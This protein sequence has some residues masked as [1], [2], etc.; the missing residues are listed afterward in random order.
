M[1]SIHD[2]DENVNTYETYIMNLTKETK[3]AIMRGD[4]ETK[5]AMRWKNISLPVKRWS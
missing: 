2:T 3:I 1:T 5:G 4:H